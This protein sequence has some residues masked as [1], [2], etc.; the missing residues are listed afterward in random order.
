MTKR[1]ENYVDDLLKYAE[2][3]NTLGV[4]VFSAVP[5]THD[6]TLR[7][8]NKLQRMFD[9]HINMTVKIDPTLLGGLRVIAGHTVIDNT[10]KNRLAEMKK[11]IYRG[12]FQK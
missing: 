4:S 2:A 1:A 11:S 6:Q 5:L 10:I 3:R 8:E 12:V 7:L 9:K